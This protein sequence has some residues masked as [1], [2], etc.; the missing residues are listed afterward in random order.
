MRPD[1]SRG[2]KHSSPKYATTGSD[3]MRRGG[4][5]PYRG[6]G[7]SSA[8]VSATR[9]RRQPG[10]IFRSVPWTHLQALKVCR[11]N[12]NTPCI[13]TKTVVLTCTGCDK[14]Y[15]GKTGRNFTTRYTEN[16]WGMRCNIDKCKYAKHI[17]DKHE[18]G[19]VN[20]IVEILKSTR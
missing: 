17:L 18:Y 19:I 14:S 9:R 11:W 13:N 7:I 15:L 3:G 8:C 10:L 6:N 4:C 5:K 2:T 12:L 20:R 16:V 1:Q